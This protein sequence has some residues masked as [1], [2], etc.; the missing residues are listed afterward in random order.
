[1]SDNDDK[2]LLM[3]GTAGAGYMFLWC[4]LR[5]EYRCSLMC[6]TVCADN[7]WSTD[8]AKEIRSECPSWA[9]FQEHR[10]EEDE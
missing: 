5:E 1:M 10:R 3:P 2:E 9:E 4:K 8:R 7:C 6:Q